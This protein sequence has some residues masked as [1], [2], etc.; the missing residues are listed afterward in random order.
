MIWSNIAPV[1]PF[2]VA[3]GLIIV[4][5]LFVIPIVLAAAKVGLKAGKA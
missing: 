4:K 2:E 3:S 5:V 1:C